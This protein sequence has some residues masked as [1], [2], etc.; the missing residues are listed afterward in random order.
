MNLEIALKEENGVVILKVS[1]PDKPVVIETNGT[2]KTETVPETGTAEV[3]KAEATALAEKVASLKREYE[4]LKKAAYR[5]G[6]RLEENLKGSGQG[7]TAADS[8]CPQ[9]AGN[10]CPTVVPTPVPNV[11]NGVPGDN[12]GQGKTNST[13]Y[14]D[15]I[16]CNTNCVTNS[17]ST[18]SD[19][20]IN[21]VT[22]N[23]IRKVTETD[24]NCLPFV[25]EYAR[26]FIPLAKLPE[27]YQKILT[28]WNN[29]PL[30]EKL[31]GL[32]PDVAQ[33]LQ[34]LLK[35]YGKA[36]LQKAIRMVADSPFLLGKSANSTWHIYFGWLLNP[37]NLKK[38]LEN[39]YRDR[40]RDAYQG[41]DSIS[42]P[43]YIPWDDE[44]V[45]TNCSAATLSVS[46]QEEYTNYKA[47]QPCFLDPEYMLNGLD[48]LTDQARNSLAH[49]AKLLGLTKAQAA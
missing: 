44:K 9:S 24:G 41:Y 8:R 18:K 17:N 42:F 29:L 19:N 40:N 49:E 13:Y 22:T 47:D 7:V 48:S 4:R 16:N 21:H 33:K 28:A 30:P 6:K 38:I 20:G 37:A 27:L 10:R 32:Y 3:A 35:E 14:A 31:K 5:A 36:N 34:N 45:K 25:P 15:Y 23:Q 11:P 46:A 2:V 1:L 26:Q 12:P 43:E 39:K